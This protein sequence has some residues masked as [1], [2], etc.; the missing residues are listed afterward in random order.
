MAVDSSGNLY[1]ADFYLNTIRKGYPPPRILNPGFNAGQFGFNPI[2]QPGRLIVESSP[3]LASWLPIATNAFSGTL[4][5][6]EPQGV[7]SSN[8]FYR[9]Q[10]Q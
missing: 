10:V 8:R 9:V 5:F 2:G 3:D 1:V 6:S 4:N 7:A